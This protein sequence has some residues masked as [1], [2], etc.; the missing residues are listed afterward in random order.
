MTR[1]RKSEL[2]PLNRTCRTAV[3]RILS[4]RTLRVFLWCLLAED[5]GAFIPGA[6]ISARDAALRLLA[7]LKAV[8]LDKVHQ[9][10][11]DYESVKRQDESW[12]NKEDNTEE[13][14]WQK[15]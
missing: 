15:I 12:R 13:P 1:V 11:R 6:S 14:L 7:D 9:A 8:S 5:L 10:E 4:D 3:E 2:A